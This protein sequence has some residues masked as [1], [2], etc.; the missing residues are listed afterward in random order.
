MKNMQLLL[1][2]QCNLN[3][4]VEILSILLKS[5]MLQVSRVKN[6]HLIKREIQD[7]N[8]KL[9]NSIILN[10]HRILLQILTSNQLKKPSLGVCSITQEKQQERALQLR[11]YNKNKCLKRKKILKGLV[12]HSLKQ[13]NLNSNKQ[14]F[15]LK[16]DKKPLLQSENR[17]HH[18]NAMWFL[19]QNNKLL[20]RFTS[21]QKSHSPR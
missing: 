20:V 12:L 19:L 5:N 11:N 14:K 21:G 3:Q 13:S 4:K 17:S 16:G 7:K 18:I 9:L 6:L 2:Q 1:L 15:L 10:L 8:F